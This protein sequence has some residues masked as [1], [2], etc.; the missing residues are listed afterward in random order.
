MEETKET[1]YNLYTIE[2]V[3][4]FLNKYSYNYGRISE[5]KLMGQ[6]GE[7]IIYQIEP[8]VPIE[9]VAKVSLEEGRSDLLLEN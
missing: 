1:S 4:E 2:A 6:G 3:K 9:T 5:I 8:F 7:N